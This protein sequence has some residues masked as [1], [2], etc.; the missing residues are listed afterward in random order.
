[1]GAHRDAR[2]AVRPKVLVPGAGLARL[3]CELA[4]EGFEAQGNE[5]AY[6]MLIASAFILNAVTEKEQ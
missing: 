3:C 6:F 2:S 5:F 1:M 4:G